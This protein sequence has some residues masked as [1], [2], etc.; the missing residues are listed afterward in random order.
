MADKYYRL[1][2]FVVD[3]CSDVLRKYF[4]KLAKNDE[5]S[6][7]TTVDAYLALKRPDVI[8][9]CNRKIIRR[10]QYKLLYPGHG[11]TDENKWDVTLLVTLILELFASNLKPLETIALKNEIRDIRNELQHYPNT[12]N[13]PDDVFDD[14]WNR[15]DNAVVLIALNVLDPCDMV[16][17]R[18]KINKAKC[19]NLPNI[20]DCLRCW[21]EERIKLNEEKIDQLEKELSEVK[22]NTKETNH[23]LRQVTVQK[24][25]PSGSLNIASLSFFSMKHQS[26]VYLFNKVYVK[27]IPC[28]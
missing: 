18:D 9:L 15:L 8:Q 28:L 3:I 2:Y 20:G 11:T 16:S 14:Y 6:S 5:G 4:V 17:L 26:T 22:S 21:Y 25:G 10:D 27:M 7:Y 12:E 1:V 13:M 24:P 23:I 19:N